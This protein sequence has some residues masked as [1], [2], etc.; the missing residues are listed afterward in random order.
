MTKHTRT[1]AVLAT[2]LTAALTLAGCSKNEEPQAQDSPSADVSTAETSEEKELTPGARIGVDQ[3]TW[4]DPAGIYDDSAH[5]TPEQW[6]VDNFYQRPVWTP[7]NFEGDFPK[8]SDLRQ[9]GFEQCGTEEITLAGKTEQQYI[10]GRYLPVNSVAGPS[11]MENGVPAGYAHSPQGA[12]M[13]AMA[14]VSYGTPDAND[15]VGFAI[16]DAWWATNK[17][18]Q[19]QQADYVN[20][21]GDDYARADMAPPPG[22]Y[23]VVDCSE[24][25]VVVEVGYDF[26]LTGKGAMT[27]TLP[28]F[29]R[30][31]DWV[32]DF[33]GAAGARYEQHGTF[34]VDNPAPLKEVRYE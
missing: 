23:R 29:W 28:L 22:F 27:S 31:G 5:A 3:R 26:S 12:V 25:V 15:E 8:K 9:G 16:D 18:L 32:P 6:S 34:D 11:R 7:K 33:S 17:R 4:P 14:V 19:E 21:E 2:A 13:L 10:Y 30:D 1:A 20:R 24:S